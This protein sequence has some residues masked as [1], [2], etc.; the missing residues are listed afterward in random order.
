MEEYLVHLLMRKAIARWI[1]IVRIAVPMI[2]LAIAFLMS[3]CTRYSS[4]LSQSREPAAE[5]P[6]ERVAKSENEP[7]PTPE[8]SKTIE[9]KIQLKQFRKNHLFQEVYSSS[10][11]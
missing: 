4:I 9:K 6:P 7:K 8:S 2:H 11:K 5:P 1:T 10:P 3:K